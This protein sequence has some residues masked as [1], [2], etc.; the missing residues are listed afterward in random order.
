VK[1][2]IFLKK[3]SFF[4]FILQFLL[5]NLSFQLLQGGMMEESPFEVGNWIKNKEWEGRADE[6]LADIDELYAQM[7]EYDA[8]HFK[9]I[10]VEIDKKLN[11]FYK[12]IGTSQGAINLLIEEATKDLKALL[13]KSLDEIKNPDEKRIDAEQK[14]FEFERDMQK[15]EIELQQLKV[16]VQLVSDFDKALQSFQVKTEEYLQMAQQKRNEAGRLC[17]KMKNLKND[18]RS[19]EQ[20]Y[21]VRGMY[22]Q[23]NDLVQFFKGTLSQETD[24]LISKID[25]HVNQVEQS[26]KALEAKGAVINNRVTV[27]EQLKVSELAKVEAEEAQKERDREKAKKNVF[28]EKR[29]K[30]FVE[31]IANY[32][33]L[34]SFV[35]NDLY[36]SFVDSMISVLQDWGI[37]SKKVASASLPVKKESNP[38]QPVLSG[39]QEP[40]KAA[41]QEAD[42]KQ[43]S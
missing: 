6:V 4:V 5:V 32:W 16:D 3:V 1:P 20:Y 41:G 9:K 14:A 35:A 19:R 38:V 33:S 30:S 43:K 29:K 34:I 22:D 39:E 17:E 37:L 13:K 7:E 31:K 24:G 18:Q 26:I 21:Q 27:L 25:A 36:Q 40:Q 8:L 42:K 28:V 2:H 23:M 11:L 15:T 12:N 10:Y